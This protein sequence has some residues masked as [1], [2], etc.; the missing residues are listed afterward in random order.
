MSN[1]ANTHYYG[2]HIRYTICKL[3]LTFDTVKDNILWELKFK[4]NKLMPCVGQ[5]SAFKG[6]RKLEIL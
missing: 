1:Q 3:N 5:H 4:T 2:R 6:S